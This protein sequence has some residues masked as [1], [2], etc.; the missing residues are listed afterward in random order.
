MNDDISIQCYNS[1]MDFFYSQELN[2]DCLCPGALL[3]ILGVRI[4]PYSL[5]N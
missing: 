2:W 4:Q 5:I 3:G 1:Q